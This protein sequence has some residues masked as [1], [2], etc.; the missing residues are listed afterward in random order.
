METGRS[1]VSREITGTGTEASELKIKVTEPKEPK[2]PIVEINAEIVEIDGEVME[3]SWEVM[4]INVEVAEIDWEVMETDGE[5]MEIDEGISR[6]FRK[7]NV[8]VIKINGE[9]RWEVVEMDRE[10][11]AAVK[12]AEKGRPGDGSGF[13]TRRKEVAR[14]KATDREVGTLGGWVNSVRVRNSL[15]TYSNA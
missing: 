7:I 4:E 15:T 13:P 6:E 9:V 10:V 8:E 2:E 14:Q 11:R 5:V 3:I 12:K 1:G